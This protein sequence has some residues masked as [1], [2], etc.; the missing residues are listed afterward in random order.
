M[1]NQTELDIILKAQAQTQAA[2]EEVRKENERL[3][4]Q[5]GQLNDNVQK[6][7]ENAVATG[8]K[9]GVGFAVAME[10]LGRLSEVAGDCLQAIAKLGEEAERISNKAIIT[11][12]ATDSVQALD[13]LAKNSNTSSEFVFRAIGRMQ[14]AAVDGK[15]GFTQLGLG[16]EE[17]LRLAPEDQLQA[18]AEKE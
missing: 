12:F 15:K 6:A 9:F 13:R 1:A 10:A 4:E 14:Q 17:F 5:I 2:F 16:A 11:G 7:G 18:V 3:R 8:A